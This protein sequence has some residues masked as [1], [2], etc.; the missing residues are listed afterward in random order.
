M[1]QLYHRPLASEC[2]AGGGPMMACRIVGR[3]EAPGVG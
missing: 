3:A 1:K 2:A